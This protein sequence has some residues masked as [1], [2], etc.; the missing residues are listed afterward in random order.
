MNSEA[1]KVTYNAIFWELRPH[2]PVLL[3]T[4]GFCLI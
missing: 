3:Y 2:A 4:I 1:N